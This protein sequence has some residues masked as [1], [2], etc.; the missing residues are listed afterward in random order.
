MKHN[1]KLIKNQTALFSYIDSDFENWNVD[2]GVF[3]SVPLKAVKREKDFKFSD[4]FDDT[5]YCSQSDA[6]DWIEKNKE[7]ILNTGYYYFFPLKNSKGVRFVAYAFERG[8]KV[9][10][11]VLKFTS[12]SVWDAEHGGVIILPQRTLNLDKTLS[13]SSSLTLSDIEIKR[14]YKRGLKKA[15]LLCSEAETIEQVEKL[16]VEAINECK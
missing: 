14:A 2:E 8:G 3:D 12:D 6:I 10:L 4:V 11:R 1:M 13:S 9:K 16:I 7:E 15:Y 5:H